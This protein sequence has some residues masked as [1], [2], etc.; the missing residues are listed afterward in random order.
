MGE[1][2]KVLRFLTGTVVSNKMNDTILVKIERRVKHPKYGKFISRSTIVHVHD[3]GNKCQIGDIVTIC[4]C[5]PRSKMKSWQL[6]KI[7]EN[8]EKME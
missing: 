3:T 5:R 4:E 8:A 1:N 7:N 2:K 6:I